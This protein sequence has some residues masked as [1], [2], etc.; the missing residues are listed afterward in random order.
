M[1]KAE[2]RMQPEEQRDRIQTERC[3]SVCR[4]PSSACRLLP[5]RYR[6]LMACAGCL[7][8]L[9]AGD[10]AVAAE[11]EVVVTQHDGTP[12]AGRLQNWSVES[13]ELQQESTETLA[14]DDV[15][16]VEFPGHPVRWAAGSWVALTTGDRYAVTSPKIVQEQLTAAW[17][18]APLRPELTIPLEYVVGL[19]FDV[20]PDR[21]LAFQRFARLRA[22]ASGQ[23]AVGLLS[24]DDLHGQL[25]SIA[26]GLVE[27][28]AAIG[29]TKLD[30]SRLRW[31]ALDSELAA[32]PDRP[33]RYAVVLLTDGSRCTARRVTPKPD[34]SVLVSPVVGEPFS[35]ALH[36][37]LSVSLF[38]PRRLPLSLRTPQAVTYTPYLS[39]RA[40]PQFDGN[41]RG[42]PLVLQGRESATGLGMTSRMRVEYK[43][44]PGDVGFWSRV[45]ID[46]AAHPDGVVRFRVLV[47]GEPA[48][49][50]GDVDAQAGRVTVP[51]VDLTGHRTLTLEADFGPRGDI[52]ALANWSD[53]VILRAANDR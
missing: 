9:V 31:V 24:G 30:Q 32:V 50:S 39:G 4:F 21:R 37:L 18:R 34:E 38:T 36:E 35:V 44:E 5:F 10:V 2:C 29:T 7:G 11:Y 14:I 47:D 1:Q 51:T 52:G 49:S 48:W 20:P 28:E 46:D 12:R 33:E 26:G 41:T 6:W 3:H 16:L 23:D 22:A 43:L 25:V 19:L 45:G 40:E 15:A 17:T 53:A 8:L 27:F 42:L 13:L